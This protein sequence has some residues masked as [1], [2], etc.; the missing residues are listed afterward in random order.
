MDLPKEIILEKAD[1]EELALTVE[2]M[3]GKGINIQKRA[4]YWYLESEDDSI[5]I[6]IREDS[7]PYRTLVLAVISVSPERS[8][9]GSSVVTNLIKMA[10][11]K[12][13][14]NFVMESCHNRESVG[15]A[16]KHDL[17]V[18]PRM[19]FGKEKELGQCFYYFLKSDVTPY[20]W[21]PNEYINN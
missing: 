18:I 21:V 8:G 16:K 9:I 3:V 1:F 20:E 2:K 13:F 4:T 11:E 12:G 7:L 10:Q 19:I 6:R 5:D 17:K 14:D 15:L